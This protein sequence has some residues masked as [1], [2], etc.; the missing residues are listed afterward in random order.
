LKNDVGRL[1][2]AVDN[3]FLVS[4]V[5]RIGDLTGNRYCLA[6]GQRAC[7]ETL[8]Q[9]ATLDELEDESMN[10]FTLLEPVDGA[11]VRMIQRR[12]NPCLAL[13]PRATIGVR[14][15]DLGQNLDRH[16]APQ[17][18]IARTVDVTHPACAEEHANFVRPKTLA[19]QRCCRLWLDE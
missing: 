14:R 6:H 7:S 19:D 4:R 10:F 8:R 1:Q 13:E 2:I 11:D 5:E 15:E 18:R 12:Q 17:R 3:S 16:V 9:R